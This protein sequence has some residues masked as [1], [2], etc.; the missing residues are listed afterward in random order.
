MNDTPIS[1]LAIPEQAKKTGYPAPFSELVAGRTKRR[2]GEHFG[3]THYGVNI[4]QLAPG[5]ASAL[6]H[7]HSREDELVFII[8]G[9][10]TLVID[11][12]EFALQ[13]GDCCGFSAGTGQAHH[14]VNRSQ[15]LV[16]YLEMGNRHA[17]DQV[18]YPHHDLAIVA[19]PDGRKV[20]AHKNGTPY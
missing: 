16:T 10:P 20:F 5:S 12:R 7:S 13:P 1:A 9:H 11:D 19:T 15:G 4:T 3:F 6:P 2:I 17:E 8:A 18:D 14:L